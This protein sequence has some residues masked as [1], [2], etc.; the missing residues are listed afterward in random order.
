MRKIGRNIQPIVCNI[1]VATA[2][3]LLFTP[4]WVHAS[5]DE[6]DEEY[7]TISVDAV[8]SSGNV[9]YALDTDDPAAFTESN[10]FAIPAGTTHTIYVKDEAGNITSQ[11]Y[12]G[13]TEVV[14]V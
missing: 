14:T 4:Q 6:E 12:P 3:I 10:E 9:T 8:D 7:I 1:L 11:E 13:Q 5:G 2:A